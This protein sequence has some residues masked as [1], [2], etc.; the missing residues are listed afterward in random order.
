MFILITASKLSLSTRDKL[1]YSGASLQ[2][3][4]SLQWSLST[5]DSF[6]T[7]EPL[8]KGQLLYSGAFLQGTA[9]LQ[10]SLSTRDSF[11]TVEPLYK[12]QL[13]YS[14]ASY[15]TLHS[16]CHDTYLTVQSDCHQS[17]LI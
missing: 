11:F 2:G 4:A 9:S 10:W 5:R 16:D 12:G 3:T 8:Y 15:L 7:V 13:L 6:F 14:G 1:L 17:A